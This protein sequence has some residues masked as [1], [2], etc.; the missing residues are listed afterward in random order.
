MDFLAA[1]AKDKVSGPL[2]HDKEIYIPKTDYKY[3]D[4]QSDY[5]IFQKILMNDIKYNIIS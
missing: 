2:E 5:Y 3:L 4:Y 1:T